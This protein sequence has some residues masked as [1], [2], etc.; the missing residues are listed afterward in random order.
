MNFFGHSVLAVRRSVVAAYHIGPALI[1]PPAPGAP[2]APARAALAGADLPYQRGV[3]AYVYGDYPAAVASLAP[4]V[5]RSRT[6]A[7]RSCSMPRCPATNARS[8]RI[9]RP[10]RAPPGKSSGVM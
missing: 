1:N 6:S 3:L 2:P 7:S 10:S 4:L 5:E 8:A 9:E